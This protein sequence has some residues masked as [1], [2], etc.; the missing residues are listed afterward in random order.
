M[1]SPHAARSTLPW[2]GRVGERAEHVSRGG[3]IVDR[4]ALGVQRSSVHPTP[5]TPSLRSGVID[6]P[7]PGEGGRLALTVVLILAALLLVE[8]PA[9]LAQ[10]QTPAFTPRDESPEDF[11]PG[12]GREETFYACVACHNF[13]LVAAQGMDRARWDESVTFMT[14]RHNMPPLEGEERRIVLDYLEQTYPPRA[15]ARPGGWQNPFAPR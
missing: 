2:R 12:P 14:Q 7:P 9:A 8:S 3:V 13:K 11:P 1:T 4:R 6:P 15:P 5:L 10:P